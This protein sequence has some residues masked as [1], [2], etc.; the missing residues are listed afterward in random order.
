MR[1][2]RNSADVALH[3][4]VFSESAFFKTAVGY[5]RKIAFARVV[6]RIIHVQYG[7][8]VG[9]YYALPFARIC[10]VERK[11]LIYA[12]FRGGSADLC[13]FILALFEIAVHVRIHRIRCVFIFFGEAFDISGFHPFFRGSA[14]FIRFLRFLGNVRCAARIIR[15]VAAGVIRECVFRYAV[16]F[17]SDIRSAYKFPRIISFFQIYDRA[18][19]F[20]KFFR[21]FHRQQIVIRNIQ[22]GNFPLG[23]FFFPCVH[24]SAFAAEAEHRSRRKIVLLHC[25]IRRDQHAV[26]NARI[27]HAFTAFAIR[28]FEAFQSEIRLFIQRGGKTQTAVFLRFAFGTSRII[29]HACAFAHNEFRRSEI[30]V[31]RT[32]RRSRNRHRKRRAAR[33]RRDRRH[34]TN[35]R[36]S[37]RVSHFT[38]P[39]S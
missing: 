21:I 11:A 13:A 9:V 16:F 38:V 30:F 31:F 26:R 35:H 17:V 20:V 4:P 10:F 34:R 32:R 36:F 18:V 19:D 2:R 33:N 39:Q 22:N 7:F 23:V 1:F 24:F 29:T 8:S 6:R 15:H 37:F 3:R 27:S 14:L 25:G 12:C 28:R 5:L